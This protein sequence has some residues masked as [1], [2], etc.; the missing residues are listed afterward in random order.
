MNLVFLLLGI[1]G[2]IFI[3]IYENKRNTP[4]VEEFKELQKSNLISPTYVDFKSLTRKEKKE[5]RQTTVEFRIFMKFALRFQKANPGVKVD[6][7]G[8]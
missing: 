8:V 7:P 6:I 1:I 3:T 5:V 2:I 4:T